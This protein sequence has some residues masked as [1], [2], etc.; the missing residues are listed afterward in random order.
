[1][2][3]S[4]DVRTDGGDNHIKAISKVIYSILSGSGTVRE[5]ASRASKI[6]MILMDDDVPDEEYDVDENGPHTQSNASISDSQ[7]ESD[8]MALMGISVTPRQ[9]SKRE[10]RTA[11]DRLTGRSEIDVLETRRTTRTKAE[12]RLADDRLADDAR[13][14]M[15]YYR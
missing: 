8:A 2:S 11:T 14:L 4:Q 6:I 3:D 9:M 1:M 12:D 5:K 13:K 10:L 15:S 7:L